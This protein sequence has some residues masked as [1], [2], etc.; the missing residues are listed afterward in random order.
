VEQA[1]NDGGEGRAVGLEEVEV[2]GEVEEMDDGERL[3]VPERRVATC[4]CRQ[5]RCDSGEG[6]GRPK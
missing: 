3:A 1:D 2:G 5:H 6:L 4:V